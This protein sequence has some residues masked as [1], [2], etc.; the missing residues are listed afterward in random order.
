[1][2]A[3]SLTVILAA[4]GGSAGNQPAT[5]TASTSAPSATSTQSSG[6]EIGGADHPSVGSSAAGVAGSGSA[7]AIQQGYGSV[8]RQALPSVVEIDAADGVGSGVILDTAGDIVTNAHVVGSATSFTVRLANSPLGYPAKLVG[9]YRPDD[10]AVIKVS[11]TSSL[12]PAR[13]ADSSKVQTGDVVLA[14]GNPLGQANSVTQGIVSAIGRSVTELNTN[15]QPGAT[16]PDVIQTSAEIN[17]GNSGGALVNL[18]GLV[19]GIPTLAVLNAPGG[20]RE[21]SGNGIGYAI[22]STITT[23][24][25]GQLVRYGKVLNPHRAAIGALART[26]AETNGQPAGVGIY[27]IHPGDPAARAGLVPGDV[28][29]AVNGQPT[30]DLET[31][32]TVLARLRTGQTV[33]VRVTH[34]NGTSSTVPVTL[35]ELPLSS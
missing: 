17:P 10:L 16:L 13:F 26:V 27:Q 30:P 33:P 15:G 34:L 25:A 23:D 5:H 31:Y 18:D 29:T 14:M 9:I 20:Q 35:G 22:P 6:A 4:C 32:V 19:I 2:A 3:V 21:K 11:G 12:R 7:L 8:V 28:I 1:M 24:I